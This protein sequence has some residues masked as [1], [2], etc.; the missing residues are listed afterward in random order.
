MNK[1]LTWIQEKIPNLQYK[2]PGAA[3]KYITWFA[4]FLVLCCTLNVVMILSDWWITG[5]PNLAEMRL[6]ISTLLSNASIAA[7]AFV[8][9][10]LVD[11]D[12]DGV[13]DEAEENKEGKR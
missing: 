10:W 4:L 13:P 9:R 2:A 3:M 8:C 1:I 12:H 6:F 11:K 7:V 5:K